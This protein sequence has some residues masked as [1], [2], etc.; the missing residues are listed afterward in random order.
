MPRPYSQDLRERVIA[1]IAGEMSARAAARRFGVSASTAVKWAQRWR[2][3]GSVAA[4]PMGGYKRS[5]LEAHAEVLLGLLAERPDLSVEEVRGALRA[6]G[7]HAGHGSVWRFFHRHGISFKKNRA[8][9][10]A[11]QGRRGDGAR[12]V[13]SRPSLA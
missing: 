7:I 6:R 3:T 11:G 4:K 10:R 8:R 5:P 1:A 13:E 2:R 12:R 9:R